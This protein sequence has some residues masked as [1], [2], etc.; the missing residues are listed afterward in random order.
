MRTFS[1]VLIVLACAGP[2]GAASYAAM[3]DLPV[4]GGEL[5]LSAPVKVAMA[6]NAGEE[7]AESELVA[8]IRELLMAHVPPAEP[9]A[10]PSWLVLEVPAVTVHAGGDW[11]LA[12]RE[13][14]LKQK[15]P[16]AMPR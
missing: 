6:T 12:W 16:P 8:R 3:N 15:A 1:A 13:A 4:Q 7:V 11:Q 10:P 2:A 5:R 9:E 14:R